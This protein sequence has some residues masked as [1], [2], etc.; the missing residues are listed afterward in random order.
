MAFELP[1]L[2]YDYGALEPHID[3]QTMTI[4][5]TKHH[6]AYLTKLNDAI[7][8]T[9]LESKS[10]EA[11]ITNL[12]SV[13]ENI[14]STVRNNGGGYVNHCLFW[15]IMAPGK[16][17]DPGGD[18]GAAIRNQFGGFDNFKSEFTNAG[19]TRFGSGWVWLV[20]TGGNLKVI[21]TPNQDNPVMD[22]NGA[23]IL[24]LDVWEH[25]YMIEYGLDRKKYIEVFVN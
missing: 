20:V 6:N 5:H 14:R 18:L 10:A 21:S 22:N 19:I 9:E 24:G 7:S 11:I 16:G 1:S 3:G 25:A 12:D 15:E 8:G 4:H 13:P 17:G 2:L 23:P